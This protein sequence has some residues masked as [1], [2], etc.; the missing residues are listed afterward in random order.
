VA[1]EDLQAND[2][3]Y[4]P[5]AGLFITRDPAPITLEGYLANIAEHR[6][7][8]DQVRHEPDQEFPHAMA[9]VHNPI[10]DLGP[11]MISL[12]CDNRKF[13]IER[14]GTVFFGEYTQPDD[15]R[16]V[17]SYAAGP[18]RLVP[19]FGTGDDLP[20]ARHLQ[21]GWLPM[22]VTSV[23][24]GQI[25]YQQITY[26]APASEPI[27][28]APIWLRDRA[29]CVVEYVV[30]N[31]G[32]DAGDARLGLDLISAANGPLQLR[33]VEEGLL[34]VSGERVLAL[35]DTRNAAPLALDCEATGAVLS[36][37]LPAGATARCTVYLP[38]W[39][40]D[41][42]D[43]T[44][45]AAG[46]PWAARCEAYWKDLHDRAM[47]I[48][49]PDEFLTNLIRASQVHCMLAARC[50]DRGA[51]IAPWISADR[52]GPLESE[53]NSVMRGMDMNGQVD[54]AQR[55]LDYF[56]AKCNDAGFIT[57]GYTVVGT[58][59]CLWT[60]GEHYDRT[61]DRDWLRTNAPE[62]VRI[63][64]W[65]A[66]QREKTKR[67]DVRGEKVP[68][69]G[70]MLPGVTADWNRFAYR[71]FN[72]AQYCHGLEMAGRALSDIGDPAAPAILTEAERYRVDIVRAYHWAQARTPVVR[73]ADGTWVP[74]DPSILDCFGRVED[75]LPGE[76]G[77]RTWCYGIEAGAHHLAANQILA[78]TSKDVDWL[79]NYLED[80][81][82]LRDGWGDYPEESNR[83]DVFSFGG[84]SKLQPYY[85]RI[86][87]VHALR[88]DVKPFVRSYFNT[89]PSLVSRENLSF[90]EHFHNMGGW[91]KTHETG[92]FL[93][94]TRTMFVTERGDELWLAPFVTDRWMG[95]GM[96]V[97]VRNAPTRFG[98]VSYTISSAV[99]E[100]RIDASIELPPSTTARKVVLRLRHPEG[101]PIRSVTVQGKPHTDFDPERDTI[102][103]DPTG[104][105][106]AVRAEY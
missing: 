28:G 12:A 22:P 74:G 93:C 101:K 104:E 70:L 59:E 41:P 45:L 77:G 39:K 3:V 23:T 97:V 1:V 8:L 79:V 54:F 21:G 94:Q 11:M 37:V 76:D 63:C 88:D 71:L 105:A 92:W 5:Y 75:F 9:V 33:P 83:N 18:W 61:R 86:A 40:I 103:L 52:Y 24:D 6:T 80:V 58:G 30:S 35:I 36:G 66:R 72:D 55:G 106:I 81:Q 48:D 49:V 96:K 51:R 78:P 46:A 50:E 84:F 26:V 38:A 82:F 56:L 91:N 31:R 100:G 16:W 32:N 67:L 34:A 95:H 102:I 44:A 4:V 62:V 53:A 13:Q 60:L 19:S 10:Q 73:L 68:E 2:C 20:L 89:I 43:Y 29:V 27:A 90:W 15:P 47:H 42:D 98:K 14:E 87:E 65:I 7:V 64:R 69:Y 17:T 99:A 25:S 57:T 85:T